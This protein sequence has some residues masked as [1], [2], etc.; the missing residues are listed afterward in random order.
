[1]EA[2]D[3]HSLPSA[4]W[5]PRKAGGVVQSKSGGLRTRSTSVQGQEKMGVPAPAER[6]NSPFLCL[7][8]L[9]RPAMDWMMPTTNPT[10]QCDGIRRGGSLG[11]A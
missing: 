2:E 10:P 9:F 6:E 5:S 3:S 1:M 7:F 8:V 4:N 11:D